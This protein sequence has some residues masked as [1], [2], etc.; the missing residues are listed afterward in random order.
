MRYHL[1]AFLLFYTITTSAQVVN[2]D[3]LLQVN[4]QYTRNDSVK[5]SHLVRIFRAYTRLNDFNNVERYGNEAAEVAKKLPRTYILSDVYRRLALCY[6]GKSKFIE[7]LK[8]YD[9]QM[10]V[11][12]QRNDVAEIAGIYLGKSA[13]FI[14]VGDYAKSLEANEQA[15]NNYIKS[16][17]LN[18]L[19]SC[20]MNF[21]I[22]YGNLKQTDK[23]VEY[24]KKALATFLTEENGINYGTYVAY[25]QLGNTYLDADAS[26]IAV[27]G[28]SQQQREQ[29]CLENLTKA[30]NVAIAMKDDELVA[31]C[32]RDLGNAAEIFGK[33]SLA[34]DNY[35]K[36]YKLSSTDNNVEDKGNI[37]SSLGGFYASN[38]NIQ[39]GIV[40]LLQALNI[41]QKNNLLILKQA[42][43]D[44]LHKAY[45][46]ANMF[47]SAYIYFQQYIAVKEQIFNAEKEK[48]ITRRQLQIDFALKE[49]DYKLNQQLTDEKLKQQVLLAQ[50]QQQALL[51]NKQQ[52]LLTEKEKDVQRLTY[53]QEQARLENEKSLQAAT[54]QKN[55]LQAKFD[56][57]VRDKRIAEQQLQITFDS[58]I[59]WL[60][61]LLVGLALL[62]TA[63]IYYNQRKTV[64]L[65]KIINQQKA[66]L[67][68]L[69]NVKDKIFSIVSHD[70]RA[71]LSS[72]MSFIDILDD[73]NIPQEKLAVYSK[74][75][76][77]SLSYTS[78]LMNNLLNW[79]VSQMQGFKPVK[80][81]VILHS[82]VNEIIVAL[83]HHITQKQVVVKNEVLEQQTIYADKNM[84]AAILRN[85]ISNAIKYCTKNEHITIQ[86]TEQI[87]GYNIFVKDEGTGMA[88][89]QLAAFNE[90]NQQPAESK[91]GTANEKGTGLGLLLCKT[92]VEQMQGTISAQ[93]NSK[94]MLFTIWLPKKN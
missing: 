73:G 58:K 47:D 50:Q 38:N 41:A 90:N 55:S 36:S 28:I 24:T 27:I 82:L 30:L 72:L 11:C 68:Q 19:S 89:A 87:D 70:M 10:E 74:E 25:S 92:F 63:F 77:K 64:R 56:K 75:L 6:Q 60:L 88:A 26:S 20:Y 15:I 93:N 83:Q 39:Q 2:I 12:K 81:P 52:L 17:Q 80:E 13:L 1:L 34:L 29:F 61:I 31:N 78:S 9:L 43:L 45:E 69:S 4:A 40:Y 86:L 8:Y 48:D 84:T 91:R 23:A 54:I 14:S 71:P 76:R 67:E 46:K 32:Y 7:A 16:N 3:S 51:L 49:H 22:I 18:N 57:E 21:G 79:A 59:K 53:L 85:L 94:G 62:F 37:L 65:N 5:V 44:K 42:T 66:S 33:K 35:L